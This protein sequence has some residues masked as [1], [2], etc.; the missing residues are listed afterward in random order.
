MVARATRS[1]GTTVPVGMLFV[2]C[3][4]GISHSKEEHV[5]M[6]HLAKGAEVLR[7]TDRS[8]LAGDG[9]GIER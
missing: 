1:N 2:P 5:E 8:L 6:G 7:D 9:S 4:R 3:R